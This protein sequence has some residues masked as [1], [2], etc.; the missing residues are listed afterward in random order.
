MKNIIF[1]ICIFASIGLKANDNDLKNIK[2]VDVK[3]KT[4]LVINS[5]NELQNNYVQ[6]SGLKTYESTL[7]INASGVSSYQCNAVHNNSSIIH[8]HMTIEAKK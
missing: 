8:N 3:S 7:T 2:F 6:T 5:K 4:L 1:I